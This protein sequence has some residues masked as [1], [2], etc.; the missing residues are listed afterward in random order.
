MRPSRPSRALERW[1]RR[2]RERYWLDYSFVHINKTGGTSVV[3]ALGLPF[4]HLTAREKIEQLGRERWDGRFTFAFVRNPWDR[5]ASTIGCSTTTTPGR[6]WR[7]ASSGTS[8]SSAT[9]TSR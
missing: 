5:V 4:G 3:V 8:T 9:G 7:G 1:L 2:L 6:S